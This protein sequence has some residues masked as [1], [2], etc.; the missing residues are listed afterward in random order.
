[1]ESLLSRNKTTIELE[2]GYMAVQEKIDKK[3]FKIKKM[4]RN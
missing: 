1:M 3:L 4:D 2:G